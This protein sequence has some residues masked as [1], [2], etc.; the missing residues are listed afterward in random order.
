MTSASNIR[1]RP[2]EESDAA[3]LFDLIVELAHYEQLSDAVSGDPE[4]LRRSLF[5]ERAAEALIVE[6]GD[7]AIG[8]AL[9]FTTFS[10]FE[11]RPGIW[12]ED[13]FVR[14]EYRRC[15]IGRELMEHLAA[16]TVKR[17]HVRLEW[18][19]L[20]WKRPALRFYRK[21]GAM[22]LEEWGMHRLDGDRLRKMGI[23]GP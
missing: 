18:C 23:E 15:G 21:L 9:F 14:P 7:E 13:I 8:Y 16:L 10:T 19:A 17:G 4:V 5:E 2:A 11:C 12:L 1:I 3:L 22:H 6:A 20:E